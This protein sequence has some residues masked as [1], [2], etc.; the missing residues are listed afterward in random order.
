MNLEFFLF[1]E[2]FAE[3]LGKSMAKYHTVQWNSAEV[4]PGISKT[5]LEA[6]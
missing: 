6:G 2:T 1:S 5:F 3:E 4:Y